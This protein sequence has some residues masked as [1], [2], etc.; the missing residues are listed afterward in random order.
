M[1]R[2]Q[3]PDHAVLCACP[4]CPQYANVAG[5]GALVASNNKY[6]LT[7]GKCCAALGGACTAAADCC[8]P[9]SGS[10]HCL[11]DGQAEVSTCWGGAA[12]RSA[13]RLPFVFG[14]LA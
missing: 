1:A 2:W 7:L 4:H 3:R 5:W 10:V 9:G 14:A 12:R 13:Q 8:T 6:M 11:K